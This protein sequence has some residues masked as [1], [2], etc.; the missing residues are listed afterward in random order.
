[1]KLAVIQ[2]KP[3]L[4]QIERN[5]SQIPKVSADIVV[6][7]EMAL[8]GYC[9]GSPQIARKYANQGLEFAQEYS[10]NK[11]L[12]MGFLEENKSMLYNSI[13]VFED[14]KLVHIHRKHHLYELD[15]FWAKASS[16]FSFFDSKFGRIGLGICM[17]L[18]P[19]KFTAPFEKYEFATFCKENECKL[20]V[21]CNNW[22]RS[23]REEIDL[24]T[25]FY[26]YLRLKPLWGQDIT[27][28]MCNRVGIEEHPKDLQHVTAQTEFAGSSAIFNL[29]NRPFEGYQIA[30]ATKEQVL[31][32]N[33]I[34]ENLFL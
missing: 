18:N 10:K 12:L 27:V 7:P 1:M 16:G 9:F 13:G 5:I 31:Q 22:L 21:C 32:V 8:T 29:K 30:S 28:A 2:T 24:E 34:E 17:D 3:I 14:G 23:S 25:V 15:E 20:I 4:R 11:L 6:L 26:W 33:F 19:Y